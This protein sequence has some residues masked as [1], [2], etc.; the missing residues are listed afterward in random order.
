MN[1]N[2]D[3]LR[4][5]LV[6]QYIADLTRKMPDEPPGMVF[7]LVQELSRYE[8]VRKSMEGFG[9]SFMDFTPLMVY[10]TRIGL[11]VLGFESSAPVVLS[12][13]FAALASTPFDEAAVYVHGRHHF[14]LLPNDEL[15]SISD[16]PG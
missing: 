7:L 14:R 11:C 6:S 12:E 8:A 3:L 15:R 1:P 9:E 13:F 4:S 2:A 10:G 5:D 16:P